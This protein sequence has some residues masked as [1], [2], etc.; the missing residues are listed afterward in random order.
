MSRD[1]GGTDLE[2]AGGL[3]NRAP[4]QGRAANSMAF[5]R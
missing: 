3:G 2:R 5:S 4:I 1:A